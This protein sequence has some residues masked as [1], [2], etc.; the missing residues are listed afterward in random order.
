MSDNN[1]AAI[2]IP[3]NDPHFSEYPP[4][5]WA[6]R[7]W[8]SGFTGS[9]GTVVITHNNSGLWTDSRYFIQAEKQLSGT[10]IRLHKVIDRSSPGI[11]EWLIEQLSAGDTVAVLSELTSVNQ[12]HSW[13]QAFE[14]HN[15]KLSP[16][17]DF[18]S[19]FWI[20]RPEL[21]K[22]K[23]FNH[24]VSLCGMSR[25]EKINTIRK[26]MEDNAC[27]VHLVT[28][29]DDIAWTLNLRSTDVECNPVFISYMIIDS[30]ACHLF[31]DTDKIPSDLNALLS[32][33]NIKVHP[34]TQVHSFL[35]Q[36]R[37]QKILLDKATINYKLFASLNHLDMVDKET[38]SIL[39]KACKNQ[40][41]IDQFRQAMI[42]DGV[43]LCHAFYWLESQLKNNQT[44]TEFEF[45]QKLAD[46]RSNEK[47]Y[48][49]ESFNAI[50]GYNANGAIVH[51]R[52]DEADSAEI[53]PEGILLVDSGGQYLNGTTD[54]TRTMALGESTQDQ[55]KAYTAVLKGM[56]GLSKAV[57]PSGTSGVQLDTFARQHLWEKGLSFSHGTGHGVGFFNSVHEGPQS[58]GPSCH[59]RA[60]RPI[61]P[62]MISS[63]EP[64][65]YLEGSYGIRIENLILC[66]PSH[67]EGFLEFETLTLFPIDTKL[68]DLEALSNEDR[69]W[70]NDYHKSVFDKLSP[71]LDEELRE[72]LKYKCQFI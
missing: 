21:P 12:F 72:W 9:A 6:I 28:M 16:I 27:S 4:K 22:D 59:S 17:N 53:K 7:E 68:I 19:T 34:Y 62:G 39:L 66:R 43:A 2:I 57:F 54:I 40:T 55:R 15:I 56:I 5:H 61:L 45:A 50:V 29:L 48:F 32:N 26:I 47:H 18:F 33:D 38:P 71:Q 20:D 36:L 49:G 24:D 25:L 52:P 23:I 1:I 37:D 60:K 51:Y 58:I 67:H 65:Y 10:E 35:A 70:L 64:G 46:C 30:E 11:N 13:S 63:N 42:K 41:E 3:T 69:Q 8:I 14:K 31:T 44:I